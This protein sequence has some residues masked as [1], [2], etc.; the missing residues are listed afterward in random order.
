MLPGKLQNRKGY[1]LY[2]GGRIQLC[3]QM[4]NL[5][6]LSAGAV[7]HCPSALTTSGIG[8][9]HSLALVTFLKEC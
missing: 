5:L 2:K 7:F 1:N 4:C 6:V 3:L 9:G 8:L